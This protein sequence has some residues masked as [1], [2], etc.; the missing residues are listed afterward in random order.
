[1]ISNEIVDGDLV[2]YSYSFGSKSKSNVRPSEFRDSLV[3]CQNLNNFIR[4]AVL[5]RRVFIPLA[6]LGVC[7]LVATLYC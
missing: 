4:S 3:S 7:M 5:K 2:V 6:E 1:M